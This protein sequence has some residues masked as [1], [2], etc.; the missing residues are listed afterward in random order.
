MSRPNPNPELR[1]SP[2]SGDL[3]IR[4]PEMARLAGVSVATVKRWAQEGLV[5]PMVRIGPRLSGQWKSVWL[6]WLD[7]G[8]G[9]APGIRKVA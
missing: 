7:S 6:A 1:W 4:R 3:I 8:R 9:V 5:P 2:G